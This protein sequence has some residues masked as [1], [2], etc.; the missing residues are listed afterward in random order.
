MLR[1]NKLLILLLVTAVVIVAA[2]VSSISRSPTTGISRELLFPEL[3][4]AINEVAEIAVMS[5]DGT[6]TIARRD[7]A[8][9]IREADDYQ[10]DFSKIRQAVINVAELEVI[11][12]KTANPDRYATLGV[13]D[14]GTQDSSSRLLT[15]KNS[16]GEVLASLIVGK[17][18]MSSAPGDKPGHYARLPDQGQALLVGGEL[19]AGHDVADWIDQ[20]LLN[21]APERISEIT[22]EHADGSRVELELDN[23]TENLALVNLPEGK[24]AKAPVVLNRMK[25]ILEKLR[26]ANVMRGDSENLQADR[27]TTIVKTR[28]GLVADIISGHINDETWIS[29]SFTYD[30]DAV[31]TATDTADSVEKT[32]GTAATATGEP[33]DEN[34]V[35]DATGEDNAQAGTVGVQAET[36]EL[37]ARTS[38]WLYLLPDYQLE[39]IARKMDRLSQDKLADEE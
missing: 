2:V 38:G 39:L 17:S 6:L 16:T 3:A 25:H 19:S 23:E 20:A 1:S 7:D 13:E 26:I 34:P 18:R 35:A 28:D 11:E 30:Q 4:D 33:A 10:A 21:I 5:N 37:G 32:A 29:F 12:A 8:W 27:T 24:E 9:L 36:A 14:P 31:Q 22:I 15:L